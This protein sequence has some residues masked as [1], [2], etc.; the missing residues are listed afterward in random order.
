MRGTVGAIFNGALQLGSA[1]GISAVNAIQVSV[2]GTASGHKG[3]ASAFWFTA[4]VIWTEGIA[5]L[6]FC[7]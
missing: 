1:V 4:A 2:D 6:I 5:V 7:E 3:R